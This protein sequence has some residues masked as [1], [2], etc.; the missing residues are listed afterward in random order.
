MD[1]ETSNMRICNMCGFNKDNFVEMEFGDG[2]GESQLQGPFQKHISVTLDMRTGQLTGWDSLW[3][4]INREE[5][6]KQ[7]IEHEM[8]VLAKNM[9]Q[10]SAS[11]VAAA[12]N[13]YIDPL[14]YRITQQSDFEFTLKNKTDPGDNISIK[15]ERNANGK[16]IFKGLPEQFSYYLDTFDNEQKMTR[17]LMI[18]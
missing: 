17:P 8:S 13:K 9:A 11:E 3:E 7:R 1:L 16:V 5:K 12:S 18:L 14:N 2:N 15:V 10:R 4:Q 6:E